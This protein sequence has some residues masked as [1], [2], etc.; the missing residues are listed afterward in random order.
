MQRVVVLFVALAAFGA[1]GQAAAQSATLA[2]ADLAACF[3]PAW[4]LRNVDAIY[5]RVGLL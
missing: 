1:A 5:R 2:P 4:Y 3:E